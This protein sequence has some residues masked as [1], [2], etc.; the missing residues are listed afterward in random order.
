MNTNINTNTS[1]ASEI[2]LENEK[3]IYLN[4]INSMIDDMNLKQSDAAKLMGITQPRVS[5]IAKSRLEKF[6][7][8]FL[9][10]S[11]YRLEIAFKKFNKKKT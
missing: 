9:F 1:D 11:K 2:Q 4:S 3:M 8:D 10:L 5:N 6:T 7:L